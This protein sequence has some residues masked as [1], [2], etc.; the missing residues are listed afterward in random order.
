MV[1]RICIHRIS[2]H[3]KCKWCGPV[4]V[5]YNRTRVYEARAIAKG[6]CINCGRKRRKVRRNGELVEIYTKYCF[7]CSRKRSGKR[8][9]KLVEKLGKKNAPQAWR[10]GR[11]RP[12]KWVGDIARKTGLN[13]KNSVAPTTDYV[14][15]TKGETNE[16]D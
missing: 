16:C 5:L 10:P 11:G 6:K 12:P 4:R 13:K 2:A 8:R 3:R 15:G 7:Q 1:E 14:E 9:K